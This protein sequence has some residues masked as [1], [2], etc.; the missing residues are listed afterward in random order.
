MSDSELFQALL[1]RIAA[2]EA[3]EQSL[4]AASNAYQAIITTILGNL[5]KPT[6]DNVI[7]M[8]DQAHEIAYARAAHR[9]DEPQKRKI[10][11]A[12]DVAQR[13]FM[14]AQGKAAQSR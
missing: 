10:K 12:D 5:D 3:R 8:I 7:V 2:L 13:M 9:C 4:T 6:R 1:Q 14:V 11:Q